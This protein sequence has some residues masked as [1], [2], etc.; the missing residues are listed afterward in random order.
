MIGIG[1]TKG[2]Y[3]VSYHQNIR[4]CSQADDVMTQSFHDMQPAFDE[5]M[6]CEDDILLGEGPDAQGVMS[7]RRA[8]LSA[9]HF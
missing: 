2:H 5:H 4:N 3:V 8:S 1:V 9:H 7:L 6:V